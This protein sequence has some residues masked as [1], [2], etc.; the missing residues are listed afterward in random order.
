ME[1]PDLL[2]SWKDFAT[3]AT[4]TFKYLWNDQDFADVT[5]ATM[6]DQQIRA[7][8]VILSSVSPFF[9]NILLN[10]PHPN[11]LIY[12]K[13]IQHKE[14][15]KIISF[16]YLGQCQVEKEELD[17]FLSAGEVLGV[18]GLKEEVLTADVEIK[19]E[20]KLPADTIENVLPQKSIET[21]NVTEENSTEKNITEDNVTEENVSPKYTS[22]SQG[23][24]NMVNNITKQ[25]ISKDVVQSYECNECDFKATHYSI[26]M[27]H[28]RCKH[29][30]I[31]YHCDQ[32]DYKST[33]KNYLAVHK[34]SKHIACNTPREKITKP[35][36]IKYGC[37]QC[38]FN[39]TQKSRL[40]THKHTK[41]ASNTLMKEIDTFCGTSLLI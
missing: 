30:G 36:A 4:N 41:H 2:L 14:L 38:Q 20:D 34:K 31:W 3:N 35:K 37:D 8:K 25:K 9:K 21:E 13:D 24:C 18:S 40:V 27:D 7:H 1:Q 23:A 17:N 15:D 12:L 5:L 16:I 10:N 39:T 19:E 32:C 22:L 29:V 33:M 6:D 28:A 26:L 11:P